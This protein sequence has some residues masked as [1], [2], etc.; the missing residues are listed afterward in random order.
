MIEPSTYDGDSKPI[1][2]EIDEGQKIEKTKA[3]IMD[4]MRAKFEHMMK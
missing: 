3:S 1:E 4:Q 2:V